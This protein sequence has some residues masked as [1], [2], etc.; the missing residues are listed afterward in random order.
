MSVA[1]IW[2]VY[3]NAQSKAN[4]I[5]FLLLVRYVNLNKFILQ[6]FNRLAYEQKVDGL[7]AASYLLGLS[8]YYNHNILLWHI[9]LNL[10]YCYFIS[11]I[12]YRSNISQSLDNDI[13][14]MDFIQLPAYMFEYYWYK[15][16]YFSEFYL[17][18]Y[19]AT[20]LVIKCKEFSKQVFE[21]KES[22]PYKSNLIRKYYIKP[23]FH[24]FIA[25]IGTL[26]QC[27][28]KENAILGSY[29]ETIF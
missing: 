18:T 15:S 16:T 2:K 14:F 19:F 9:N 28:S 27:H 25:L 13:T 7:L 22:Y 23:G 10:L 11:I 17:Y 4:T 1:I 21:F 3:E 12:F 20:I 8:N 26:F 24:F 6:T 29:P 5:N